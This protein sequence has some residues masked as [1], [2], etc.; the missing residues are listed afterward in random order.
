VSR[1]WPSSA[2]FLIAC[3]AVA[4]AETL[5]RWAAVP[6]V[7][8][9]WSS[10]KSRPKDCHRAVVDKQVRIVMVGAEKIGDSRSVEARQWITML[11]IGSSKNMD[12]TCLRGDK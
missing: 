7:A 9:L 6:A 4:P 2:R 12:V 3:A 1:R 5:R 8:G 11:V 10:Y